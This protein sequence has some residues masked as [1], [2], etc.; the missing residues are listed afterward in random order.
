V[1]GLVP[2]K[3]RLGRALEAVRAARFLF[4]GGFFADSVNRSHLAMELGALAVLAT[5]GLTSK[6]HTG[7]QS[8]FYDHIAKPGL[9][10][11]ELAQALAAALRDRLL[12]DYEQPAAEIS[13]ARA[14]KHLA[15]AETF[16]AAV[17]AFLNSPAAP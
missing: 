17:E 12:T 13:R 14:E 2:P 9:F 6:S 7:V 15:N 16:L 5:K 8:L 10:P 11:M 1:T 3:A 4:D